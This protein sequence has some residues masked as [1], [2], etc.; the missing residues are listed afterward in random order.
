MKQA[1]RY[2]QRR[3]DLAYLGYPLTPKHGEVPRFSGLMYHQGQK[4]AEWALA[5]VREWDLDI[6]TRDLASVVEDVFSVDVAV[7]ELDG[8][9]DGIAWQSHNSRLILISTSSVPGRQRFTLA[10]ELGHLLANDAQ[11]QTSVDVDIHDKE[12]KKL[13]SEIRANAFSASFLMPVDVLQ[14]AAATSLTRESFADLSCS[15][16]VSPSSL[17][18]R[19]NNL[20]LIDEQACASFGRLTAPEAARI[21]DRT[22]EFAEWLDAS[23]RTRVPQTLVRDAFRAYTDG[24]TTLRPYANLLGMNVD[25]LQNDLDAPTNE[26]A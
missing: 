20:S 2:A 3:E 14:E 25:E 11:H 5:Q 1:E 10:H 24:A 18:Y 17:A 15:L 16:S 13:N 6:R 21:A 8:K 12:H 22:A 9:F 23:R 4:L 19:M 26:F 7:V